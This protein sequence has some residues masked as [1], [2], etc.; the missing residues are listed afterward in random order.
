MNA[1]AR[2]FYSTWDVSE[3]QLT[4]LLQTTQ[5]GYYF[6]YGPSFNSTN[7]RVIPAATVRAILEASKTKS[8]ISQ[9]QVMPSSRRFSEFLVNDFIGCWVGDESDDALRRARSENIE[10]PVRYII[11]VVFS[12]EM[13]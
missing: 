1:T 10:F 12:G 2:T 7:I 3:K 11:N 5:S 8:Y 4:T 13:Q 9:D 6:L